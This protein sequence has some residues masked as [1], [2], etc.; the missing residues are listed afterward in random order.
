MKI[1]DKCR[2]CGHALPDPFIDFG[3]MPLSNNLLASPYDPEP[4]YPL[5]AHLC[6]QCGLVQLGQVVGF[7]ELY[8][9]SYPF[10]TGS[11]RVMVEHYAKQANDLIKQY[12]PHGGRVVEIGCNDCEVWKHI[13]REDVQLVGIDPSASIH[14]ARGLIHRCCFGTHMNHYAEPT[15]LII[16][17]NVL[18]HVD[19]LHDF[20]EAVKKWLKPDGV[21]VVEVPDWYLTWEKTD[22]PQMY[23]EHLSYF[24]LAPFCHLVSSHGL[25]II[26]TEAHYVHGGSFRL[27]IT[28]G[29]N[30]MAGTIPTDN[31]VRDFAKYSNDDRIDLKERLL[32]RQQQGKRIIGYCASAKGAMILNWCGIGTDLVAAVIDCTPAKLAKYM[33]GTHQFI[34][35]KTY[36]EYT[37]SENRW[38]GLE[39]FDAI[40]ILSRNHAAEIK[41]KHPGFKGEWITL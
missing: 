23:H 1:H 17:N 4:R 21:M 41:A 37:R 6:P 24:C 8:T 35:N 14:N 38:R 12:V 19:D 30:E 39:D 10:Q 2:I 29:K 5:T 11:S 13:G 18:G 20:M 15:D 26:H 25:Q 33:P 34:G 22:F 36:Q 32:G 27:V 31:Q 9:K 3:E 16:A 28:H 40:L 7:D